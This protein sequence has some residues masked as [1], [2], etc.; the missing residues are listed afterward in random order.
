MFLSLGH[1]FALQEGLLLP[2]AQSKSELDGDVE[3]DITLGQDWLD[4]NE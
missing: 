4:M 1:I 2:L 3:K